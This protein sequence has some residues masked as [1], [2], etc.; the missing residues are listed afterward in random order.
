[1]A[2][3]QTHSCQCYVKMEGM[4][5]LKKISDVL[6]ECW[7]QE[8]SD[9]NSCHVWR[10]QSC[11]T[12][13]TRSGVFDLSRPGRHNVPR[14]TRS[15]PRPHLSPQCTHSATRLKTS[16]AGS[17]SGKSS[18]L[19]RSNHGQFPVYL[20]VSA[21]PGQSCRFASFHAG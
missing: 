10:R 9:D 4:A 21:N 1:M 16:I 5:T 8:T 6:P 3:V 20:S 15:C 13:R 11:S 2:R 17:K 7:L 14:P 19:L 12:P 18:L